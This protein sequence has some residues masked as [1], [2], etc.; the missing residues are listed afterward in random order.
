MDTKAKRRQVGAKMLA[1]VAY[2][3]AHPGQTM[4]EIAT[5][6]LPLGGFSL[7]NNQEQRAKT[8]RAIDRCIEYGLVAADLRGR[9]TVAKRELSKL[10][11]VEAE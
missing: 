6:M 3:K 11:P 8:Y 5:G 4:Y 9:S 1:I 10:Y 7:A 2:V